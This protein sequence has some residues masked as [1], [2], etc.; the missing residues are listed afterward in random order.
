MSQKEFQ[1]V[2]VIENAAGGRLSVGETARL[3]CNSV[4][5]RCS[6][7]S[8]ATAPA[9]HGLGA[10]RQPRPSHALGPAHRLAA[11]DSAVGARQAFSDSHLCEVGR[12]L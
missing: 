12:L 6:G 8:D 10:T 9:L 5:G 4:N 2:K 11:I 1:R 7:S 3:L